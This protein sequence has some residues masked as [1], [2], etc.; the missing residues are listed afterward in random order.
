[1]V[2]TIQVFSTQAAF[3][4]YDGEGDLD[5]YLLNHAIF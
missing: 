5:M 2:L 3:L 1:M 4:D